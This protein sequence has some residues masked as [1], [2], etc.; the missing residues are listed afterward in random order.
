VRQVGKCKTKS[1]K[2][3][4]RKGRERHSTS[5]NRKE[6]KGRRN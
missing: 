4:T 2:K 6:G 5:Y 1:K 3:K